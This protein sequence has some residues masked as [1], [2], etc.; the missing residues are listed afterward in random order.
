[1]KNKKI[2][3]IL[4][5][6]SLILNLVLAL[7]LADKPN[8]DNITNSRLDYQAIV[9]PKEDKI[10][11][12]EEYLAAVYIAVVD[13]INLPTLLV[14]NSIDIDDPRLDL[15]MDTITFN[16]A[17]N[18]FIYSFTPNNKG[19]HNWGGKLLYRNGNSID[20]LYFISSYSVE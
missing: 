11:L 7:L 16:Q 3:K 17:Y 10:T 2:I 13:T 14:N 6:S 9:L 1:M 5:L 15:S 19:E 4:F 20:S 8:P 18:T 12:G